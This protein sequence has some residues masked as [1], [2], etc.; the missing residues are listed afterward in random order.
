MVYLP[1]FQSNYRIVAR[2]FGAAA[3]DICF[4]AIHPDPSA[5]V[6]RPQSIIHEVMSKQVHEL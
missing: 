4:A 6:A 5:F 3:I 2:V 1:C